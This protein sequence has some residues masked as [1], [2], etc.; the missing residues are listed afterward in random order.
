M[1]QLIQPPARRRE[2]ETDLFST[3]IFPT[4]LRIP[5]V[6]PMIKMY[7]LRASC[8][9]LV[10]LTLAQG[11]DSFFF[12]APNKST[13]KPTVVICPGFG[14]DMIDYVA[15][16][17][18]PE[19]IGF[20][21]VLERRGFEVKIVPVKRPDWIR[22]ALGLFDPAFWQN[23]QLASGLAYGWYL[24]RVRATIDECGDDKVLL[25][26]HSAGG[27]L[28]RATLGQE[29]IG[30]VC[31]LVTL[32]A[33]HAPPPL[34]INCAT[35]GALM[36]TNL[37]Y[38]GSFLKTIPYITVAGNAVTGG[39]A[40]LREVDKIY[41]ERGEK[42]SQNV[43]KI[44]Y[45]ALVGEYLGVSGDGVIPIPIAHLEGAEQITLD[46]VLH[47]INEAGTTMPTDSWYGSE[48]VVDLWLEKT[49]QRI[50]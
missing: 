5:A 37:A 41:N 36:N 43:A 3:S 22:V 12:G 1:T 49:L 25:I 50:K 9:A 7:T 17:G 14:N 29:G 45:G 48:K 6:L 42:S 4:V 16:L 35:R 44:N 26:A 8:F 46:G 23:N 47:S 19:S 27:W 10:V 40:A 24:D 30:N 2:N 31:G 21:S 13:V 33:P 28:A 34:G 39:Q 15:P 38:P 18:A 20:K 11:V 32:G